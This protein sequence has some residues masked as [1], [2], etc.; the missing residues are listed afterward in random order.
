MKKERGGK[1]LRHPQTLKP[2]GSR[3]LD[4]TA[5][6]HGKMNNLKTQSHFLEAPGQLLLIPGGF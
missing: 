3:V 5:H 1:G 4:S 6:R 2:K